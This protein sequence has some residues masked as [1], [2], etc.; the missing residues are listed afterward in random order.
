M[1]LKEKLELLKTE[2]T[3]LKTKITTKLTQKEQVIT[4]SNTKLT[5]SNRKLETVTK[6]NSENEKVL[7]QLLK[8][9]KELGESLVYGP[10]TRHTSHEKDYFEQRKSMIKFLQEY[11][12]RELTEDDE[13]I[14]RYLNSCPLDAFIPAYVEDHELDN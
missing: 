9:F 2:F 1:T 13:Q 6:E 3:N 12:D 7:E 5:E 8:E 14:L 10:R 4:E 11:S